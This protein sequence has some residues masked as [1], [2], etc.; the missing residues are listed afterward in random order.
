MT[1][2]TQKFSLKFHWST[3]LLAF[4][5]L[6]LYFQVIVDLVDQWWVDP[7]YSHGFL[8]PLVSIFLIWRKKDKLKT[9]VCSYCF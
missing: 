3:Y 6:L 2:Q 9:L 1:E 7:N 4:L 5:F 8:V